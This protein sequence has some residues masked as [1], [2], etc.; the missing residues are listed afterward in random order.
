MWTQ[1]CAAQR[2]KA[3]AKLKTTT[4]NYSKKLENRVKMRKMFY[5]LLVYIQSAMVYV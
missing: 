2:K 3:T 4:I 5:T 1:K